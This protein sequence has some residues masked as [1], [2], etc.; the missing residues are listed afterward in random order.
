MTRIRAAG[1]VGAD[2]RYLGGAPRKAFDTYPTP[3]EVTWALIEHAPPPRG[4][5]RE[6][7]CGDGAMARVLKAAGYSVYASD[8]RRTG[9][10]QGGEDY[11]KALPMLVAGVVTNPPFKLAVQFIRKAQSEAPYVAMLLKSTFW[12]AES[13]R[14][15]FEEC[16]PNLIL[17]L[18]WRP[19]FLLEERGN[20]PMMDVIWCVWDTRLPAGMP[21]YR[22]AGKPASRPAPIALA[23]LEE[24]VDRR[25]EALNDRG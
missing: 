24:A 15:L 7:A 9:Y 21:A 10:G 3:P 25:L 1:F 11:L 16:P 22:L 19:A 20:A 17:A 14:R 8:I 18:T 6:P 2:T 23:A 5:L 4:V 13:R 12:H